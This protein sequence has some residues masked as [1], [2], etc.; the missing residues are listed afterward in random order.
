MA[1]TSFKISKFNHKKGEF[2][3][4]KFIVVVGVALM[5]GA[6]GIKRQRSKSKK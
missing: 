6:F 3:Y 2:K 4:M 1:E 5:A